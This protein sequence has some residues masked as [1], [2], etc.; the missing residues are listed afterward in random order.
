MNFETLKDFNEPLKNILPFIF[1]SNVGQQKYEH[2]FCVMDLDQIHD[3][4]YVKNNF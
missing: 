3:R 2:Y 4:F 1:Y